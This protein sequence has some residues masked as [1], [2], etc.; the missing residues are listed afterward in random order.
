MIFLSLSL[1]VSFFFIFS[2]PVEEGALQISLVSIWQ[3]RLSHHRMVTMSL[4]RS[5]I[6]EN[7]KTIKQ[8]TISSISQSNITK[9]GIYWAE[10]FPVK[11]THQS[12]QVNS[13]MEKHNK[14]CAKNSSNKKDQNISNAHSASTGNF[15]SKSLSH[16]HISF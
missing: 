10:Q 13:T 12:N 9:K 6:I 4:W 7:R 1:S 2:A 5:P 8:T 15:L 16:I 3:P 11:I 14:F